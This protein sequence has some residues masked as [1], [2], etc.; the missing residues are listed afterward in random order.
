M[1]I[2]TNLCSNAVRKIGLLITKAA[3]LGMQLD[4]YGFADE[5]KHSGNVYLYLEDYPFTLY[6]DLGSD[7]IRALWSNPER[8]EEI[9]LDI[10][11]MNLSQIEDWAYAL[12]NSAETE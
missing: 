3:D 2:K 11:K 8:A 5:N 12:Y 4:G 6:I 9:E 10:D 1:E 7:N